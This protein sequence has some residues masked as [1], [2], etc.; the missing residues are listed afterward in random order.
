MWHGNLEK[1]RRGAVL[2]IKC[3]FVGISGEAV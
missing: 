1:K 2:L 3:V